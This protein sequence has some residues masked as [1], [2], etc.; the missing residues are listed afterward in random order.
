MHHFVIH[1]IKTTAHQIQ[2]FKL[3]KHQKTFG[4]GLRP[5]PLVELGRSPSPLAAQRG[6]RGGPCHHFTSKTF[7]VFESCP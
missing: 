1:L 3:D 2:D 5:D 6:G 4:G 7:N